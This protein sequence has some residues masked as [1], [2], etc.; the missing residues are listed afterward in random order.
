ME[1]KFINNTIDTSVLRLSRPLVDSLESV[2]DVLILSNHVV[3]NDFF[4][5]LLT[6]QRHPSLYDLSGVKL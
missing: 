4:Q 1:G 5:K 2:T 3:K 6:N